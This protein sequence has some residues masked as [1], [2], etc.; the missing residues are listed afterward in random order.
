MQLAEELGQGHVGIGWALF[1]YDWCSYKKGNLDTETQCQ[2]H[3]KTG[4][5]M[6]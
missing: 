6:S 3:G 5:T 1:Q 4:M 2:G